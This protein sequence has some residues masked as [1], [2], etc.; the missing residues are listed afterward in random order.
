MTSVRDTDRLLA[1][2]PD[3]GD[4][5][6]IA[7]RN[8]ARL[9][10]GLLMLARRFPGLTGA[11]ELAAAD[12]KTLTYF[13]RDPVLRNAFETDLAEAGAGVA[14][15]APELA[16]FLPDASAA[17]CRDLAGSPV[18]A[19]PGLGPAFVW[20]GLDGTP[21]DPIAGRLAALLAAMFPAPTARV[22]IEPD[23][24]QVA[25]L[26]RGAELLT[27]LMPEV[28]AAVLRH[29]G[30]VGLGR[31]DS[32]EGPLYSVSGGDGMPATIF[33]SPDR[34]AD[35]WDAAG[36]ILHEG[37]HLV[38]F[39][40]SRCGALV[41]DGAADLTVDI[42]W[43]VVPW[44][45][46][47]VLFAVH[48]YVHM[49]AFTAAAREAGPEVLARFGP[50][51]ANLAMSLSTP[52]QVEY[53][54]PLARAGFLAE[55]LERTVADRLTPYGRQF[56]TWLVDTLESREPGL[57]ASWDRP[58]GERAPERPGRAPAPHVVAPEIPGGPLT[59]APADAVELP[60]QARLVLATAEPAG[61]HWLNLSSWLTY[62]LCDGRDAAAVEADYVRLVAG[63]VDPDTARGQ[64]RAGLAQL[65]GSGLISGS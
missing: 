36:A 50:P 42:P 37:L 56:V 59:Q 57:R 47:R 4:A 39:E 22:P 38:L 63:T 7:R 6:A 32:P 15:P 29:I 24:D 62:A 19:W 17:P 64:A 30:V 35:P 43:R 13:L 18:E 3:F 2:H 61:V 5:A 53:A 8:V 54:T 31:D 60:D 46:M 9:R 58:A 11:A 34:V 49:V 40:I 23:A 26:A 44:S 55:Q 25:G 16:R 45:T 10:V 65:A 14:G 1:A 48:V 41:V 20:T 28:G 33:L 21:G 12:E 27:T 51:P 52:G